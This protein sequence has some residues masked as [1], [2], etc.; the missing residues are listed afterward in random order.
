VEDGARVPYYHWCQWLGNPNYNT[1]GPMHLSDPEAGFALLE[2]ILQQ[3][4]VIVLCACEEWQSCHRRLV[5]EGMAAR[6]YQVEHLGGAV[7]RAEPQ[8]LAEQG[9]LL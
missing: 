4:P 2:D 6:G 8:V 3:M 7:E 5:A 9:R 1:D